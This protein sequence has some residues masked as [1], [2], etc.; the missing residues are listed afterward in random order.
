MRVGPTPRRSTAGHSGSSSTSC[1]A[2][3]HL[4]TM[5]TM[6]RSSLRSRL[7]RLISLHPIGMRCLMM[8]RPPATPCSLHLRTPF[9]FMLIPCSAKNLVRRLLTVDPADRMS[10]A[11]VLTVPWVLGGASSA[12]L[13]SVADQLRRFNTRRRFRGGVRKVMAT[14]VS[15]V[16]FWGPPN[17]EAILS[18]LAPP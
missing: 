7:G 18:L 9:Y 6:Q 8:V 3:F 2:A 5:K 1:F 10:A 14:N 13:G 16:W 4:F 12:P 17:T 11:A 15:I